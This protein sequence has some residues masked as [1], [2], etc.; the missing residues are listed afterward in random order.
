MQKSEKSLEPFLRKLRYQP[1]NQPIITNNT[2]L[3][4]PR[5]C[6]SKTNKHFCSLPLIEF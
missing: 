4:R 2:D 5:W 6:R 1:T 3:I